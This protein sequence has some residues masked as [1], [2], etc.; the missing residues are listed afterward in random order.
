MVRCPP[1][2]QETWIR[3][4][5]SPWRVAR[6]SH[7]RDLKKSKNKKTLALHWRSC[8]PPGVTGQR[9][10]WLD[11]WGR[12][13]VT[14]CDRTLVLQ[15]LSQC[16]STR[17]PIQHPAN[18]HTTQDSVAAKQEDAPGRP[19][20]TELKRHYLCTTSLLPRHSDVQQTN[21]S[22]FPRRPKWYKRQT[23]VK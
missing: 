17:L 15:L 16:G 1:G 14:G 13:T 11:R 7:T 5:L 3:F 10:D 23:K 19:G 20:L 22:F 8:R 2:K 21:V 12:Y 9:W 6:S 18:V 4:P